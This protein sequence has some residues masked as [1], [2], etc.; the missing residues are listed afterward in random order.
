MGGPTSRGG[1]LLDTLVEVRDLSVTYLGVVQALDSVSLSVPEGKIVAV[2]GA[3]GAGKTT[4]LRAISG[5][6][7]TDRARITKGEIKFRGDPIHNWPPHRTAG[8]GVGIAPERDKVFGTL[9]VHENLELG[10]QQNG[11]RQS[12]SELY[13]IAMDLFPI[14]RERRKQTA[15][16][17]SGGERQMLAIAT[18]LV[19]G[20]KLFLLDEI[21]L[22]LAPAV[23]SELTAVI[24]RLNR[25]Y[26]QSILLVDQ[27]VSVAREIAH[28]AYILE[29]GRVVLSGPPSDVLET[30]TVSAAY[31]GLDYASSA[32]DPVDAVRRDSAPTQADRQAILELHGIN[33]RFGGV[34][35]LK[36][37]TLAI[38]SRG[39]YGLIGPNG[40]GKT[41][42]LNCINGFYTPKSG[43]VIFDGQDITQLSPHARARLGLSRTFQHIEVFRDDTVLDNVLLGRHLHIRAGLISCA[44]YWG[45]ASRSEA[46]HRRRAEEILDLLGLAPLRDQLTGN[47]PYRQQK[48]VE[49]GRALAMEPTLLLLDEPGSGMNR[50]EK[51]ELVQMILRVGR[52]LKITLVLIEHDIHMI[53]QLCA[54]ITVLNAGV[55][56]AEGPTASVL[57]NPDVIAA[58]LGASAIQEGFA[59]D[60]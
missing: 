12:R 31:L 34:V 55:K 56:I 47:L 46:P 10:L 7:P 37:V 48:L 21:S 27:N 58:Y 45:M 41:S 32:I 13:D 5:F 22:G 53:S 1:A 19:S 59:T 42:L 3:N 39:I 49:I 36:D 51:D 16:Y 28:Q 52:E 29:N 54:A 18:V 57:K 9:T 6:L 20:A 23:V 60:V 11:T 35:A 24:A 8:L 30:E 43:S 40:A 33:L 17:L 50:D 26:G 44:V 15:G 25:L 38:P 2:L 4:L 14:L